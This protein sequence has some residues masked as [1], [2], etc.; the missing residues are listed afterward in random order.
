MMIMKSSCVR[1]NNYR[2]P[3][4]ARVST[5]NNCGDVDVL[6]SAT[7]F[8]IKTIFLRI[9]ARIFITRKNQK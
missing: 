5:F 3:L 4:G 8:S 2:N 9:R 6:I 1:E 7:F